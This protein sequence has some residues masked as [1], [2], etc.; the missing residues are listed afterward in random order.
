MSE[1]EYSADER[2]ARE[3]EVEQLRDEAVASW[4]A[5]P[6]GETALV[7]MTFAAY[8]RIATELATAKRE[9]DELRV[10]V[11]LAAHA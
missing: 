2:L 6:V 3:A 9:R 1:P 11:A 5:D 8:D 10:I 4:Q 7:L